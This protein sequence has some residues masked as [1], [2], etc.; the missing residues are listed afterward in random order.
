[1][2]RIMINIVEIIIHIVLAMA[3]VEA[4]FLA[5]RHAEDC[6]SETFYSLL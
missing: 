2:I 3:K 5:V 1:M 6:C 4:L